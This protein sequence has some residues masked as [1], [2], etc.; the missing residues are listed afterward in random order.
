MPMGRGTCFNDSQQKS[1]LIP[2]NLTRPNLSGVT[3]T[4]P[5][6]TVSIIRL[7]AGHVMLSCEEWHHV[8]SCVYIYIH[9]HKGVHSYNLY[10]SPYLTLHYIRLLSVLNISEHVHWSPL[11]SLALP[12]HYPNH[13]HYYVWPLRYM[14]IM[15]TIATTIPCKLHR[16]YMNTM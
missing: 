14:T 12:D 6:V 1:R 13:F 4:H 16:W 3:L 15:I 8:I 5:L 10:T 7:H 2:Q 11:H 9:I